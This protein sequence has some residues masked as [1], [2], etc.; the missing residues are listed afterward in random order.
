MDIVKFLKS[1]TLKQWGYVALFFT[2]AITKRWIVLNEEILV[3]LCFI[4]F[5]YTNVKYVQAEIWATMEARSTA[6]EQ[7]LSSSMN[8]KRSVLG[9][10]TKQMEAGQTH[11]SMVKGLRSM[12]G[13]SPQSSPLAQKRKVNFWKNRVHTLDTLPQSIHNKMKADML[14]TLMKGGKK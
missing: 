2:A 12:G 4:A 5:M 14:A 10:T 7:E 13:L 11:A 9:S 3:L 1:M 8:E 6:I